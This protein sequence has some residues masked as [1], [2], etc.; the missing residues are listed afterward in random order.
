MTGERTVE[1]RMSDI[2]TDIDLISDMTA[3]YLR[4]VKRYEIMKVNSCHIPVNHSY[5]DNSFINLY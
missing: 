4:H 3:I 2:E 1:W 5:S